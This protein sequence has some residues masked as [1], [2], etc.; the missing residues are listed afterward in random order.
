MDTDGMLVGVRANDELTI[1]YID[2]TL[3]YEKRKELLKQ[4][5]CIENCDCKK[6]KEKK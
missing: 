3:S 4:Q 2:E 5:Y 1:S 6:C